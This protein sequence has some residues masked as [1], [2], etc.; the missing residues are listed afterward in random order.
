[1]DV[2]ASPYHFYFVTATDFS[3]N[4]GAPAT[5]DA[6]TDA[7]VMPK[8]YILSVSSYPNPF[9][10]QTTVRYTVPSPGPVTVASGIYFARIEQDASVRSSKLVLLR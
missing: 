6:L 8:G 3:G 9:N 4:E 2:T 1:M 5:L 7:E 10:P